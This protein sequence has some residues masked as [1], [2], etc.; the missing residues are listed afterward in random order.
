MKTIIRLA[1]VAGFWAAMLII[2]EIV[3]PDKMTIGA[4]VLVVFY[5]ALSWEIHK[6]EDRVQDLEFDL[7]KHQKELFSGEQLA[8]ITRMLSRALHPEQRTQA[9]KDLGLE[10]PPNT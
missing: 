7:A 5:L 4:I 2:G 9:Y 3:Q 8:Y 6:L 1:A 10:P